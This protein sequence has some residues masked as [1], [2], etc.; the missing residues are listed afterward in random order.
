M[1]KFSVAWKVS[2]HAPAWGATL[3]ML[4]IVLSVLRFQSTLPHGERRRQSFQFARP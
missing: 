1:K 4:A 2:I 3:S